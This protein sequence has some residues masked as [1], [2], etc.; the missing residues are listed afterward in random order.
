M[1]EE[2]PEDVGEDKEDVGEDKED[3]GEDKED[4]VLEGTSVQE[5]SEIMEENKIDTEPQTKN[6]VGRP[7][8]IPASQ[9]QKDAV[10]KAAK[11]YQRKLG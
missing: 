3:V 5:D 6:P 2:Y 8:G 1:E 4:V 10:S 11:E 9:A 7:L